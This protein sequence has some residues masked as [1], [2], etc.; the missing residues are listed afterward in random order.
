[1]RAIR[2]VHLQPRSSCAL[3]LALAA[4]SAAGGGGPSYETSYDSALP[5]AM[6][7]GAAAP[8]TPSPSPSL[9]PAPTAPTAPTVPV[10]QGPQPPVTP[11][12]APAPV[13][14]AP[15]S[16]PGDP[17]PVDPATTPVPPAPTA[18]S[19]PE[20]TLGGDCC[21]DGDCVCHGPDPSTLTDRD[22]PFRVDTIRGSTGTIFYPSDAEPPFAGLA[23]AAGFLNT[24][25]EILD[26]GEFFASHGIV[27]VVTTT[28]GADLPSTRAAKLA[29]SIEELERLDSESG[30]P[31][32]GAMSGRYGTSGYSMGGGGTTIASAEDSSLLSSVGLAPWAPIG[33]GITTP[34]LLMCGSTDTVA[35]CSMAEEAFAEI[36]E[37]T[38]KMLAVL[39]LVAH[40]TWLR[41]P[42]APA[43]GGALALA[44]QKLFLEGDERWRALLVGARGDVTT[45]ISE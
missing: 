34:T 22:G 40:L 44:F 42:T 13:G 18:P 12:D 27:T 10:G 21:P 11:D 25:S 19:T 41:G 23:I 38:P 8:A 26:W 17:N 35:P 6:T 16:P 1:M 14:L 32:S 2:A 5:G 4:C 29:G 36:P 31:L 24:G 39:P 37:S 15:D 9:S 20:V 43:T 28:T 7:R 30:S 45:N 33:R 3:T